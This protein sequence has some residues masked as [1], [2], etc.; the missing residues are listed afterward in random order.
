MWAK[1][2]KRKKKSIQ[3]SFNSFDSYL[4]NESK[5]SAF[6]PD[7]MQAVTSSVEE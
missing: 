4:E 5:N 7:S 6:K 2:L 3:Q 1:Q